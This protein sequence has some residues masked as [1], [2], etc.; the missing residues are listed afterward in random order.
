MTIDY[1]DALR[2]D[3]AIWLYFRDIDNISDYLRNNKMEKMAHLQN[4]LPGT[5]M[6]ENMFQK[7]EMPPEDMKISINVTK[8]SSFDQSLELVTSHA[9]QSSIPGRS[10]RIQ[11]MEDTTGTCLGFI[12]LGSPVINLKP[13]NEWLE[14]PLSTKNVAMM[15]RFNDS[16]MMGFIIVPVQ[17]FGFNYLGGKLLAALCCCHEV[18]EIV[19]HKYDMNLCHFET[20]SLYG[21]SK[22]SSQYDGMKPFLRYKGN[23][24][25]DFLPLMTGNQ[26]DDIKIMAESIIGEEL[27]PKDASSRKM[28][29]Q[30]K[31]I[32]LIRASYKENDQGL[33]IKVFD[34]TLEQIGAL[35]EKKRVYFGDYGFEN[36]KEYLTMQTDTL[37]EK[38]DVFARHSMENVI[39]WWKNKATKRWTSLGLDGRLRMK[40][41]LWNENPE[42]IDIIR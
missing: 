11:V 14:Q 26:W 9:I 1:K 13:R 35:T 27:V 15:R 5:S 33:R 41:E 16:S 3:A 7:W 38:N 21:T 10:L 18:R 12:R 40:L 24:E 25:S 23:T 32:S 37:V 17:P 39:E 4:S 34:E 6:G 8:A 20:T 19:N 42:E 31:I 2:L 22:S 36:V 28:K 29:Q 30:Q